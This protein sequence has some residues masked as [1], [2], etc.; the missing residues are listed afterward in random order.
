MPAK[1][2]KQQQFMA[3]CAHSPKKAKGKCPSMKVAKEF[4]HGKNL[5]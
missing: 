2:K 1:T 5:K 4:S 3:I